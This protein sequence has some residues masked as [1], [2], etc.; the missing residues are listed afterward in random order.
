MFLSS[1]LKYNTYHVTRGQNDIRRV[2]AVFRWRLV[3]SPGQHEVGTRVV[4]AWA[5]W[6]PLDG[7]D[8]FAVGLE[9][10]DTWVLLHTPDLWQTGNKPAVSVVLTHSIRYLS[11]SGMYLCLSCHW[12]T[13]ACYVDWPSTSCRQ[14]MKPTSCQWDPIWWHSP[15]SYDT[16]KK[17]VRISMK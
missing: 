2:E 13:S 10:M 12:M 1:Y 8:F 16:D 17:H 5:C 3:N 7:V 9:V 4:G 11:D 14:S 6:A 15:H